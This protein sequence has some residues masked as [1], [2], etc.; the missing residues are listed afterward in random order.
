MSASIYMAILFYIYSVFV[1]YRFG[2][3]E[4]LLNCIIVACICALAIKSTLEIG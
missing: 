4:G 1:M 3:L 2:L